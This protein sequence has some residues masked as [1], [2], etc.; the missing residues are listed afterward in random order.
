MMEL[1]LIDPNSLP[2]PVDQLLD[3]GIKVVGTLPTGDLIVDCC[4]DVPDVGTVVARGRNRYTQ[5]PGWVGRN[6]TRHKWA[7]E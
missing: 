3:H 6:L 7:G 4:G 1:R 5:L 2:F